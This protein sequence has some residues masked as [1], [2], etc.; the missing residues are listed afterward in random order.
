[1]V[2][3]DFEVLK[4]LITTYICLISMGLAFHILSFNLSN[5][6]IKQMLNS[7]S[8]GLFLGLTLCTMYP[9]LISIYKMIVD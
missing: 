2:S 7:L 6:K 1:M 3:N 9:F 8:F 4:S 5:Q